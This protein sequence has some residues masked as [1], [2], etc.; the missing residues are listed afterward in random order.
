MKWSHSRSP[1]E[2]S[3]EVFLHLRGELE[4]HQV[5]EV[6]A[7]KT[8]DC[9]RRVAGHQ[10]LALPED[11]AAPL[12]RPDRRR[13]GG[14]TADPEPLQFLDQ[15]RFSEARRWRR[16]MPLRFEAE[17]RHVAGLR[18]RGRDNGGTHRELG[19]HRLLVLEFGGRIVTAFDV[20]AA[21]AGEL[22]RLP[23]C[24]EHRRFAADARAGDFDRRA[25]HACVHHL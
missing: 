15:R 18:G 19:Q 11:V 22:D 5:G 4:I 12:D 20:G 14:R 21:E 25:K 16:F 23:R 3:I 24:G 17:Q 1:R 10:R 9:K 13:V 6:R 7:E 2:I 8:R